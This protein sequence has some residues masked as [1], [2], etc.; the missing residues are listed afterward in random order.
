[1]RELVSDPFSTD[2]QFFL[3]LL[4]EL[5]EQELQY[6]SINTIRSAV[7]M[8][9]NKIEGVLIGQHPL[10]SRL[11][12]GIHNTRPPQQRN[13]SNCDVEIVTNLRV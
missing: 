9:H 6:R 2:V 7:L 10:V 4:A 12:R 5:F 1:M 11:L 3:D 13:H 8:T